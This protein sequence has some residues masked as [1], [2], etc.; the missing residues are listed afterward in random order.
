MN[1]FQNGIKASWLHISDLH[2]I[3]AKD[4]EIPTADTT[5]MQGDFK[6]LAEKIFP[7]FL[8]VTGDFRDKLAKTD[9]SFAK[10]YLESIL[11]CFRIDKKNVFLV[12]GNH[13]AN[14]YAGRKAAI[15][16]ILNQSEID[17]YNT[18]SKYDLNKGFSEYKSFVQSFYNGSG[19]VDSRVLDPEGIYCISWN[20]L[21]NILSV[22]TALIS[23]GEKHSQIVDINRLSQCTPDSRLPTIMIGHHGMESLYQCF[24]SRVRMVIDRKKISA[25]LHG[26]SHRYANHPI[27]RISTPN[28]SIPSI[29]CAKS[30]PQ[31]GD[32]Y[33]DLGV[34]YYE[35]RN[36][37]NTYIQA[38][39][40]T[41]NGFIE[42]SSY[43]YSIDKRYYFPMLYEKEEDN[44]SQILYESVKNIL[45][46]HGSFMSGIWVDEAETSWRKSDHEGLGRCL[47]LFYFEKATAGVA[48]AFVH[49]KEIHQKL[50]QIPNKDPN[51]NSMLDATRN[52][53]YSE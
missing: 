44:Q 49:A 12:P 8:V 18:Y 7:E 3:P 28:R 14:D 47:L 17:D 25:Y 46:D 6:A 11:D 38:Y 36:D 32:K 29:T 15:S 23:D 34:V 2:V 22:N 41:E 5:F 48:D 26:D 16:D 42:D 50:E 24:S 33:S 13:D 35:W 52:L 37:G 4:Q 39:R 10:K 51:T 1:Y 27:S 31:S 9:F 21:L 40:W 30:A 45:S 53:L 20:N 43:Y 19:I